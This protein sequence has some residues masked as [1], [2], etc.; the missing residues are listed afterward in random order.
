LS[1]DFF[2]QFIKKNEDKK[3]KKRIKIK[4]IKNKKRIK[5]KSIKKSIKKNKK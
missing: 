4:S 3:N 5:I 2:S 1:S